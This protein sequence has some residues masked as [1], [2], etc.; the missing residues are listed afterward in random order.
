MPVQ[1]KPETKVVATTTPKEEVKVETPV[2]EAPKPVKKP[3]PKLEV[4]VEVSTMSPS[5]GKL[6]GALA[7]AH[8]VL[9][10]G[11]KD[12]E[13]Y[14]YNYME[15]GTIINIA[16]KPLADNG[17]VIIQSHAQEGNKVLVETLLA[18]SSGE[19]VKNTLGIPVTPMKQLSAAQMIGVC[20][21]YGRRYAMQSMLMIAG[22]EDTDASLKA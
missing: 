22:E 17:L 16:R 11:G 18:H 15:L 14:G 8:L 21:T 9:T 7:K 5:V 4:K 12:K 19:W 3:E 10:N 1:P 6:V 2:V 13:G 20:M